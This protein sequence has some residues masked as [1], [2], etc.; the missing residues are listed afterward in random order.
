[1][2]PKSKQSMVVILYVCVLGFL[3]SGCAST[4]NLSKAWEAGKIHAVAMEASANAE[5]H[6]PGKAKDRVMWRLNQGAALRAAGEFEESNKAF[7]LAEEDI[8]QFEEKARIKVSQETIAIIS[9]LE[10]LDYEG[11]AYD[12]I[13]MNTYKAVNY[14]QI[15]DY[16]KA[17][18]EFNRALERQ[19]DAVEINA[20]RIE[21]AEEEA[22]K[23]TEKTG[24]AK[25]E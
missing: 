5:S 24:E 17:R 21:K 19:R 14:L 1:M 4:K 9:N 10:M 20:R 7:D 15:G 18:V 11:H 12:K 8:D 6:A 3:G 23:Q 22:Q 2:N 16:E 25:Q 13:M